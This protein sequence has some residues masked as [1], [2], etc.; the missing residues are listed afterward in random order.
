M[1]FIRR[2]GRTKCWPS[3]AREGARVRQ[4]SVPRG[5]F[6]VAM[7]GRPGRVRMVDGWRRR[8][9]HCTICSRG[10]MGSP[11]R[12]ARASRP[13]GPSPVTVSR[14][15]LRDAGVLIEGG[16]SWHEPASTG[17]S[18]TGRFASRRM[19]ARRRPMNRRCGAGRGCV[20]ATRRAERNRRSR[21]GAWRINEWISG[22]WL[23]ATESRGPAR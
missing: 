22:S 3:G 2:N 7:T 8:P 18:Q 4:P 17:S 10:W 23:K 13:D 6:G 5:G 15:G 20:P 11:G 14:R 1:G 9:G 21:R 16:G 12:T 19:T